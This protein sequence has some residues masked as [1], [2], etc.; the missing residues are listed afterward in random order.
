MVDQN[1]N[2]VQELDA[3]VFQKRLRSRQRAVSSFEAKVNKNRSLSER[4]ADV[5]T[6]KLGSMT[7][8]I[9]NAIW[10]LSWISINTGLV[11]FI[12]A[13][14][15]FPFGLLT[16]IVSLEAIFLAIIVLISQNRAAR[17]DDLREEIDLQINTIAEEEITK[18]IELQVLLLQKNGID[19]SNDQELQ[20][21][22]KPTDTN[23]IEELLE[24][25][26]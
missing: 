23:R 25:Q 6:L 8:L 18:I 13:F 1:K 14:D 17:I 3:S 22:L 4:V 9:I 15:P 5:I 12:S 10:F 11:P 26:V 2:K 21:M 19:L 16:M 20:R 7:F 24:K